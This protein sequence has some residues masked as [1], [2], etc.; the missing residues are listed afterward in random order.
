MS[1]TLLV[2]LR[3]PIWQFAGFLIS[4]L[5]IA[6][7]FWIYFRQRPAR[8]L[9]HRLVSKRLALFAPH[10]PSN[11]IQIL[12]DGKPVQNVDL[13]EV[14]LKNT[15]SS[16]ILPV[17][18]IKPIEISLGKDTEILSTAVVHEYPSGLNARLATS[19]RAI[20]IEP[21]LLNPK[22]TLIVRILTTGQKPSAEVV[23]RVVGIATISMLKS[24]RALNLPWILWLL[25][26]VISQGLLAATAADY[27]RI[28]FSDGSGS[29]NHPS[30]VVF[31]S[32]ALA[33]GLACYP[34]II[35]SLLAQESLEPDEEKFGPHSA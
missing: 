33:L 10:L 30:I 19:D 27:F 15:G 13:L 26:T 18:F 17:D 3:D 2:L 24:R 20:T 28:A 35:K 34:F 5:S 21:L 8:K 6:A 29:G 22:D 25:V 9:T 4:L 1:E 11:Q 23:A 14:L 16:A 12:F 31:L 32:S 7:P